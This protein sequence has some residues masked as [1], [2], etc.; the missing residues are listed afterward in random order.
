MER[1]DR[2]DQR[3]APGRDALLREASVHVQ[4]PELQE[5]AVREAR[6][7]RLLA[8]PQEERHELG[9]AVLANVSPSSGTLE[10][11]EQRGRAAAE[12]SAELH[13]RDRSGR[14]QLDHRGGADEV[15]HDVEPV[16]VRE[17]VHPE[18]E[19]TR[20]EEDL[21]AGALAAQEHRI[22][23]GDRL[24]QDVR[25]LPRAILLT[26]RVED[27]H[28]IELGQLA[29]QP[30]ARPTFRFDLLDDAAMAE[31]AQHPVDGHERAPGL[32]ARPVD[33]LVD[34]AGRL[35]RLRQPGRAEDPEREPQ[36]VFVVE[37]G[38]AN[39]RARERRADP[40][41][42]DRGQLARPSLGFG[43][44]DD[45]AHR[46][47]RF[48]TSKK[49]N[50][51]VG[52]SATMPSSVLTQAARASSSPPRVI[53]TG[54][55]T[56]STYRPST[57]SVQNAGTTGTPAARARWNGPT[58]KGAGRPKNGT[59]TS[60]RL[61][62]ARSPCSA[63][64]SPRRRAAIRVRET[65]G[66]DRGTKRRPLPSRRSHRSSA[67]ASSTATTTWVV[68]S[69]CCAS[70]RP[71]SSQL[72]TC[73]VSE[74]SAP[75][76]PCRSSRPRMT[77]RYEPMRAGRRLA[78]IKSLK[79]IANSPKTSA[80]SSSSRRPVAPVITSSVLRVAARSAGRNDWANRPTRLARLRRTRRGS[81]PI[82]AAR[83]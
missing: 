29:A 7:Q 28:R 8:P 78:V 53:V 55:S 39:E 1:V 18:T 76:T 58:G 82:A 17:E 46:P 25:R 83:R 3:D 10:L 81:Q 27:F 21:L 63:T 49:L 15:V 34:G 69:E 33:E 22:V 59:S 73:A 24:G 23:L 67:R 79:H 4:R 26:L 36:D 38:R 80:V 72:P 56:R 40:G 75:S 37:S 30:E 61:P 42:K 20:R 11:V 44:L 54:G 41:R 64:A 14:Q 52:F 2:V 32:E 68:R 19:P 6:F 13:D 66:C 12:P 43:E 60:P 9:E 51:C 57:S 71:A 31:P 16:V 65:V 62:S 74:I 70:T 45:L 35:G 77:P 50:H 48:H 47:K 5:R